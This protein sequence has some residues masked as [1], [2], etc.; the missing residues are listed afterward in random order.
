MSGQIYVRAIIHDIEHGRDDLEAVP[1]APE[2]F[3]GIVLA[4]HDFRGFLG[5]VDEVAIWRSAT[6]DIGKELAI[7]IA[8]YK[9]RLEQ[10]PQT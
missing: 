8:V 1:T 9:S 7:R 3:E 2:T 6:S 4:C 5:S 10:K